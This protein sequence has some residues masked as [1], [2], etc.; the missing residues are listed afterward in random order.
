MFFLFGF[1]LNHSY[2]HPGSVKKWWYLLRHLSH[3][4][5]FCQMN[6]FYT[7]NL[8]ALF[9]YHWAS[10][11]FNLKSTV[12][13]YSDCNFSTTDMLQLRTGSFEI[14]AITLSALLSKRCIFLVQYYYLISHFRRDLQQHLQEFFSEK[15]KKFSMQSIR[16]S[17][18]TATVL[19][20]H[21]KH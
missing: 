3:I 17:C 10:Q 2:L 6:Q 21:F 5:S 9:T 20:I 14:S 15:K 13:Y 16:S 12:D 4:Q 19:Q 1:F 18:V 11:D 8:P 7:F